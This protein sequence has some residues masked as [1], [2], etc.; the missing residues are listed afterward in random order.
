MDAS[1]SRYW[2]SSAAISRRSRSRALDLG[3]GDSTGGVGE[4]TVTGDIVP[5][6]GAGSHPAPPGGVPPGRERAA[7]KRA[8]LRSEPR[9]PR[10]VRAYI[11]RAYSIV[12]IFISFL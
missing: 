7:K 10:L 2:T 1:S 9:P 12:I 8:R 6:G 5:D 11:F 4:G 3:T